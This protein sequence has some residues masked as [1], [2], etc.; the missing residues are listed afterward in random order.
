MYESVKIHHKTAHNQGLISAAF[1]CCPKSGL[2][3]GMIP[4]D[5]LSRSMENRAVS[6]GAWFRD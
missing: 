1:G 6:G 5:E 2:A 4:D 3:S